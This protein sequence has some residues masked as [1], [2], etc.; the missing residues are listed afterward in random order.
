MRNEVFIYLIDFF[1]LF[2]GVSTP[3]RRRAEGGAG[4]DSGLFGPK[5]GASKGSSSPS[6]D[7]RDAGKLAPLIL[8]NS[9]D[10][11]CSSRAYNCI[12]GSRRIPGVGS[13]YRCQA[14]PNLTLATATASRCL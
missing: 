1:F 13:I 6:V 10:S 11:T 7:V 12:V 4:R 5:G 2:F 14:A 3:M 9:L 8:S